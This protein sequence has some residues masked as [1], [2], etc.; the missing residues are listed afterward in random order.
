MIMDPGEIAREYRTASNKNKQI[1]I[2]AQLNSC[3]PLKIAQILKDQGEELTATWDGKLAGHDA[4]KARLDGYRRR[5]RPPSEE[6]APEEPE[7]IM[8]APTPAEEPKPEAPKILTAGVLRRILERLPADTPIR[9]HNEGTASL[10]N[11]TE[12]YDAETGRTDRILELG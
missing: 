9:L 7:E 8:A 6:A 11:Y 4:E 10:A 3:S 1:P 2:L 12:S 5:K